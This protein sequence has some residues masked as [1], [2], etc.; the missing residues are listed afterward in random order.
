MNPAPYV[1]EVRSNEL[2]IWLELRHQLWPDSSRDEL[3]SE[4]SMLLSNPH[5]YSNIVAVLDSRIV[6]FVEVSL[7]ERADGCSTTPVGYVEGWYVVPTA[8]RCGL[9]RLLIEAAE[10]WALNRGCKEIAS[11]THLENQVG[12][13]AH[14][15]L[16]FQEIGSV[17]RFKKSL[18]PC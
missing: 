6:G 14:G 5:R 16:G 12:I 1:R 18:L 10:K 7:H 17:T 8:R 9:G 11:D 13:S 15:A 2:D 3:K 4:Q